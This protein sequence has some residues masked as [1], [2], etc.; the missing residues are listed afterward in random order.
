MPVTNHFL[1]LGHSN[2]DDIERLGNSSN[3][4]VLT[5]TLLANLREFN[6][7]V[8]QILRIGGIT[9]YATY[10]CTC[11]IGSV[12]INRET[13]TMPPTTP[14]KRRA[15]LTIGTTT[16]PTAQTDLMPLLSV[17]PSGNPTTL[18]TERN[19]LSD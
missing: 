5:D 7:G 15:L 11:F 19:I 10:L 14:I 6:N 3:P 12:G 2:A 4:N 1:K 17:L 8:P 16:T 9:Q 13:E 18:S